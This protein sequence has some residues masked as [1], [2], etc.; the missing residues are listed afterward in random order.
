MRKVI[1]RADASVEIG[2]GHIIRCLTVAKNLRDNGCD[3]KFWMEPLQGNLID[4]VAAEGFYNIVE[5]EQANLYIIDHYKIDENWERDI[6]AFTTNIMIIDDLANRP[7]DCDLLLDQNVVANFKKRYNGL[8]PTH[9]VKLL[10]PKYLMMRDEFIEARANI[11]ERNKQV[12]RLLVFMGGSDPTNET[13]KVLEALTSF[14]FEHIDV[15]VGISNVYKEQIEETCAQRGY[16]FHCQINYMARLMKEA[17]FALGAG[18]ATTWERCYVGLPSSATIVADNQMVT[19]KYAH[20]LGAVINLGWHGQVTADTYKQLLN[21]LHIQQV[22][23]KGLELTANKHPNAWLRKIL[24]L[25][26]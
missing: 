15:V 22:G 11:R 16:H 5:A 18:G 10:G 1:I 9:C 25:M 8:V 7:H 26:K 2:S 17:D 6:R 21:N 13:M 12:E 20:E 24:E 4:Y 23:N 19:T 14:K 3:V